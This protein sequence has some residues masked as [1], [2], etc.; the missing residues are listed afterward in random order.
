[1]KLIIDDFS[2]QTLLEFGNFHIRSWQ[3]K[4]VAAVWLPCIAP[5]LQLNVGLYIVFL[6][7]MLMANG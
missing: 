5:L 6:I 1:M 4:I 7:M 2:I 3:Q